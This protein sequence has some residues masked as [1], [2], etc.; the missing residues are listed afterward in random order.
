MNASSENSATRSR[1]V[2]GARALFEILDK[3]VRIVDLRPDSEIQDGFIPGAARLEYGQLV[4]RIGYAEGMLPTKEDLTALLS[5]LGIGAET[6][7]IACDQDS[8]IRA[9]RLLWT[10]YACNHRNAALLDGGVAAW[11]GAKLPLE[12]TPARIRPMPYQCAMDDTAIADFRYVTDSIGHDDRRILDVRSPKEYDGIDVRAQ[13]GGH[14]PGAVHY[15]WSN[16]LDADKRLR[17]PDAIRSELLSAGIDP[18]L[19]IIPYCQ[20]NRRSAHMFHVLKW[21]GYPRVRAYAGSWSE[22]GNSGSAP[23]DTNPRNPTT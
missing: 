15:E 3:D 22:W 11:R 14:V 8:G 1:L 17:N 23:I 12:E 18:T 21:L 7:V 19:E 10:L 20:S 16:V 9:T 2:I 5:G 13:R 6:R 4:R